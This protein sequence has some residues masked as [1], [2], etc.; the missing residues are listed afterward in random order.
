MPFCAVHLHQ[1]LDVRLS[2]LFPSA[3]HPRRAA[4]KFDQYLP[5]RKI[6]GIQFD[7]ALKFLP[8]L[9]GQRN[10]GEPSGMI[11]LFS[12]SSSQPFV[13]DGILRI[14]LDRF[15][16]AA[17][18]RVVLL[19]LQVALRQQQLNFAVLGIFG[20]S[21]LQ[22]FDRLGILAGFIRTACC[23]RS[24]LLQICRRERRAR[25]ENY[26]KRQL[27]PSNH[28][29]FS[30]VAW[31][32]RSPQSRTCHLSNPRH[33]AAPPVRLRATRLQPRSLWHPRCPRESP[34]FPVWTCP[35]AT[36]SI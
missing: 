11:G 8:R 31:L 1:F 22:D 14:D 30:E 15:L 16:C 34:A 9:L 25:Q 17:N 6:P 3:H 29:S 33:P 12:V 32:W 36:G 13:I 35:R 24:L 18:R 10:G 26:Y 23:F 4:I 28:S 5:R 7:C 21:F 20:C 2:L 27:A 19:Q